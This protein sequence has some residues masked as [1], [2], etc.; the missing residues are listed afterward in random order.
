MHRCFLADP[1]LINSEG[2]S[3]RRLATTISGKS[4]PSTPMTHPDGFVCQQKSQS[5]TYLFGLKAGDEVQSSLARG[6]PC[7]IH[8][9]RRG[10]TSQAHSFV[11]TF[12]SY[13]GASNIKENRAYFRN[14]GSDLCRLRSTMLC[15][16]CGIAEKIM[17]DRGEEGT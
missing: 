9:E 14:G 8:S 3:F 1:R 6:N 12:T 5:R 7:S 2:Q 13:H 17:E 4:L 11:T 10:L 15:P 16:R